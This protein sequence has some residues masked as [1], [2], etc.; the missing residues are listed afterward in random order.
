MPNRRATTAIAVAAALLA[1]AT[2]GVAMASGGGRSA[3]A[4]SSGGGDSTTPI[5]HLVVLFQENVSFDHYFGTYPHAANPA[6]EPAFHAAPGTP[7]RRTLFHR[8]ITR[9]G[10]RTYTMPPWQR[11]LS[12]PRRCSRSDR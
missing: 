1:T 7:T 3:H 2:G 8:L 11:M 10:A 4:G 12:R 9:R 5:K 6:S